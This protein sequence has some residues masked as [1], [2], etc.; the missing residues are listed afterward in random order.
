MRHV[1]WQI[2]CHRVNVLS[3]GGTKEFGTG[4]FLF[5]ST[6]AIVGI[7]LRSII[8]VIIFFIYR[9]DGAGIDYCRQ[10]QCSY[11]S[12]E[13]HIE[14]REQGSYKISDRSVAEVNGLAA[15]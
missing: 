11:K 9:S 7:A 14:S 2:R 6:Q 15:G 13:I 10:C 4:R 12:L 5:H 1:S 3:I 8:F